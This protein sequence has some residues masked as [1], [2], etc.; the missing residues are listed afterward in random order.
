MLGSRLYLRI[1]TLKWTKVLRSI[2]K[3]LNLWLS[4]LYKLFAFCTICL[5]SFLRWECECSE[6]LSV[7]TTLAINT[8][9][10]SFR[11]LNPVVSRLDQ[12][13]KKELKKQLI[14]QQFEEVEV[15]KYDLMFLS[16]LYFTD[17]SGRAI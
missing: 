16:V 13:R 17:P 6:V 15:Y 12:S 5:F 14:H 8:Y 3:Y 7:W 10:I 4:V 2:G 11:L 9:F 1:Q